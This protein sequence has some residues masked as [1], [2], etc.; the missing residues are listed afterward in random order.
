[1]V[2]NILFLITF[3]SLV[4][5]SPT[6]QLFLCCSMF[7]VVSLIFPKELFRAS[8]G[9]HSLWANRKMY[10]SGETRKYS[11]WWGTKKRKWRQFPLGGLRQGQN[12]KSRIWAKFQFLLPLSA[13]YLCAVH[14][15]TAMYR[16]PVFPDYQ[17][18]KRG[19]SIINFFRHP[20]ST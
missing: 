3:C 19:R 8:T 7:Y 13:W 18:G 17:L 9:F 14:N 6:S 12:S 5:I 2:F 11:S 10:S 15:H 20:L 16:S 4:T 1:M